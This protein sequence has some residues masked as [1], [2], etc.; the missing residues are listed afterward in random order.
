LAA[1]RSAGWSRSRC[2]ICV[3]LQS[4]LKIG[5]SGI[6]T[7]AAKK[8]AT[9]PATIG[10]V[11]TSIS[12]AGRF[13]ALV[14]PIPLLSCQVAGAAQMPRRRRLC[15][16]SLRRPDSEALQ[17]HV[18]GASRRC[19]IPSEPLTCSCQGFSGRL[20]KGWPGMRRPW[21]QRRRGTHRA[22]DAFP[23]VANAVATVLLSRRP[24]RSHQLRFCT[25]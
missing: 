9:V 4:P 25:S 3:D 8:G 1:E 22:R 19:A 17:D 21:E 16:P 11:R 6:Q 10:P 15:R 23:A 18:K 5:R 20:S 24:S 14:P 12:I 7:C 13:G 2:W